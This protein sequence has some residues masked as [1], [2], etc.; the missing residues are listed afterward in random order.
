[1][2]NP[3]ELKTFNEKAYE[4]AWIPG[5]HGANRLRII[6]QLVGTGKK[7]LDVGCY[8]GTI[9][10]SLIDTG[11][12]VVGIDIA[13]SAIVQAKRKKV[14]AFVWDIAQ[15]PLPPKFGLFD[16]VVAGEIVEHVFDTD[17]FIKNLHRALKRGGHL[18]ITTPNL[19]GL[20]PRLFLLFG[21]TPWMIE[22]RTIGIKAGH[23]RYFTFDTLTELLEDN[24]FEVQIK[25]TDIVG[26]GK[27]VHIPLL[28]KII[29]SLG[30]IVFIKAVKK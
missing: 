8:D 20:G 14:N 12:K 29:P 16:V 22:N 10:K 27:S 24:G 19:A 25:C 18:I 4:K 3:T 13:K 28:D 5:L 17:K 15:K 6:S 23:I 11:N 21:K 2:S 1:M 7:I 9:A 26:M 30:R